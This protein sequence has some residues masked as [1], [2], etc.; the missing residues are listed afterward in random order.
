[1]V[2][3]P[4]SDEEIQEIINNFTPQKLLK[5]GIE[6]ENPKYILNALKQGANLSIISVGNINYI[7]E[8]LPN[9]NLDKF[10][11]PEQ[12]FIIGVNSQD[13]DKIKKGLRRKVSNLNYVNGQALMVAIGKNDVTLVKNLLK[14]LDPVKGGKSQAVHVLSDI[15]LPIF[16]AAQLG[17]TDIVK[18]LLKDDRVEPAHANSRALKA[19]IDNKHWSTVNTLISDNR[20]VR[21]LDVDQTRRFFKRLLKLMK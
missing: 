3:N 15:Q 1:M 7:K 11:T 10:I 4:K 19:A 20:V 14:Y 2:F 6:N 8:L 16:R 13:L 21:G 18:V 17:H 12:D 5:F 9:I